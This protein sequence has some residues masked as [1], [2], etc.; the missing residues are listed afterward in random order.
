M[1]FSCVAYSLNLNMEAICSSETSD[2]QLNTCSTQQFVIVLK[3]IQESTD[4]PSV[5]HLLKNLFARHL[6]KIISPTELLLQQVIQ[7]K[8]RKELWE[9]LI[10]Y[11]PSGKNTVSTISSIV[12]RVSIA[13]GT[14]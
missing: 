12:A 7:I 13:A 1:L 3:F 11:Y 14:C 10:V 8:L 6:C 4:L 5:H 9:E 2:F